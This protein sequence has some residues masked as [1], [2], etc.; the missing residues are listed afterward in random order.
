MIAAELAATCFVSEAERNF[1]MTRSKPIR[2]G[3][4]RTPRRSPAAIAAAA[5][6]PAPEQ[7]LLEI[8]FEFEDVP[9]TRH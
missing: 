4:R 6:R 3:A 2:S 9:P 5:K 8:V 1:G 7:E